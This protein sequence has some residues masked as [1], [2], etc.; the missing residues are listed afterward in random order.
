MRDVLARSMITPTNTMVMELVTMKTATT[1]HR[2]AAVSRTNLAQS[3][4]SSHTGT[5]TGQLMNNLN[6]NDK[7][8]AGK[9]QMQN[10]SEN[11]NRH[12]RHR[13]MT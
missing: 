5:G 7:N 4:S 11:Q 10:D 8:A 6:N 9:H 3:S 1:A 12:R 2:K 13:M